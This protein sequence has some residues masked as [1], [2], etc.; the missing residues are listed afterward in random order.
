VESALEKL[1]GAVRPS[2]QPAPGSTQRT[3]LGTE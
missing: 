1:L 2:R 3:G